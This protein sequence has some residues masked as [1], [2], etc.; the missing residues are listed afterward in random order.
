[1]HSI[2]HKFKLLNK[3]FNL[4]LLTMILI[5]LNKININFH[6]KLILKNL[7][8]NIHNK[9]IHKIQLSN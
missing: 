2:K 1:M 4:K 8:I 3:K 7:K 9:Q 5:I 6:N